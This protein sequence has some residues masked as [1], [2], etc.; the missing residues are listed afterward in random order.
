MIF[1]GN[2]SALKMSLKYLL[3]EEWQSKAENKLFYGTCK[4]QFP[5]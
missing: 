1:V 3:V 2:G 5:K 4:Y